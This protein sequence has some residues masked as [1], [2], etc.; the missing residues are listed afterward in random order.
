MVSCSDHIDLILHKHTL[1]VLWLAK[2]NTLVKKVVSQLCFEPLFYQVFVMLIIL[3]I[4]IAIT[5]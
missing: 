4:T 1:K 2:A 3:I 5:N